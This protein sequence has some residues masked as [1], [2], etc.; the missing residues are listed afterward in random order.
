[1][2]LLMYKENEE[3]NR[4][5]VFK[6]AVD[7]GQSAQLDVDV[8]SGK[9]LVFDWVLSQHDIAFSIHGIDGL[10]EDYGKQ[11][12]N[13][14]NATPYHGRF[15]PDKGGVY[16]LV[17]DNSYSWFTGKLVNYHYLVV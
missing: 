16:S 11:E 12:C 7:Q 10:V 8:P 4:A 17:F 15:Q 5:E 9:T 2:V 13:T 3:L 1:M 6:L 14:K